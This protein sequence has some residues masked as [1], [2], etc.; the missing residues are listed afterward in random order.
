[1][2]GDG[3]ETSETWSDALAAS[4]DLVAER[5]AAHRVASLDR[6]PFEREILDEYADAVRGRGTVGDAGCGPGVITAYLAARGIDIIG[7]DVSSRMIEVARQRHP[8]I[9]F[10]QGDLRAL[11]VPDASLVGVVSFYSILHLP[12]PLVPQALAEIARVLRPT[13]E[14]LI[15]FYEGEGA[16]HDE[17]ML[18][19]RVSVD[20]TFFRHGEMESLL[21]RAGLEVVASVSRAPTQFD[22]PMP[23]VYVRAVRGSGAPDRSD[24][25][26]IT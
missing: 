7:I 5:Y 23:S 14:A 4:Y 9:T 6:T 2:N 19:Q 26:A 3:A 22:F 21:E 1:M 18:E 25:E 15:A 13:G 24:G 8:T 20:T 17:L 10:R 11:D 12:R 16:Q